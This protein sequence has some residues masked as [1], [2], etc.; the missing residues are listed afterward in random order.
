MRNGKTR[1]LM[2]YPRFPRSFW[3]FIEAIKLLGLGSTMPPLG[4]ATIAAMLRKEDFEIRTIID[5]NFRELTDS[6]IIWAELV[7]ISAMLVQSE[8]VRALIARLKKQGKTVVV[9]GPFP[10]SYPDEVLAMGADHIIMGEA[11]VTL[12]PFIEDWNAGHPQ[13]IYSYE[14]VHGRTVIGLNREGRPDITNTPVPRWDLLELSRYSSLAVQYSRGC[15]FSCEFCDVVNLFGHIPRVKTSDQMMIE[16]EEI[17]QTGW[18]GTIFL[19]DDNFIGNK[20][21]VREFLLALIEWQERRGFPFS[22][23]TEASMNLANEDMGEILDLMVEAGFE[24]VFVGIESDNPDV[25]AQMG[26]RQNKGDLSEKV[27][28]I[29]RAGLNVTAGFII[30]ADGDKPEAFANMFD[31]IQCNGIVIA[32]LGLM[33]AIKGTHLYDRLLREGRLRRESSGNNTHQ[34]EFNFRPM[35]DERIL[36]EGYIDLLSKLYSSKN[37]YERCLT[38]RSKLGKGLTRASQTSWRNVRAMLRVF[39]HNLVKEPDWEFIKYISWTLVTTPGKFPEAITAAAK[40]LH[41]REITE[42]TIANYRAS[43][44]K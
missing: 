22:F 1:V 8:A 7:M 29:Q 9:G 31:F 24:E 26:K 28:T 3:D 20:N 5:M 43:H 35:Q 13:K 44:P 36:I 33:T 4:L 21:S 16:I 37:Y 34:F 14:S 10:T 25:L 38:L 39:Y 6:D 19:V 32:M 41:F 2:I 27:A 30:G 11:E 15:P 42:S 40:F 17:W 12:P 18:R 23:F